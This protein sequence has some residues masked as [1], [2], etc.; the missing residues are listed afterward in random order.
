MVIYGS[1]NHDAAQF[2]EGEAF[3][4]ER[5][6]TCPHLGFGHGV[7]YCPGAGLARQEGRVAVQELL[8]RMGDIRM[9]EGDP[10]YVP[11]VIQRIPIR[12]PLSFTKLA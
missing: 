6:Q 12:L 11:S 5:N 7:H 3:D 9:T 2:T 8:R 4:L 1:G 10:P